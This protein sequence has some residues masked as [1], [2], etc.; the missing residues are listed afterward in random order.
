M[1]ALRNLKTAI[2]TR[3]VDPSLRPAN[4]AAAAGL[5][6]R[7]ANTLLASE[8]SSLERYIWTRRLERGRRLL[9]DCGQG[10]RSIADIAYAC[11]FSTPSHFTRRFKEAFGITPGEFRARRHPD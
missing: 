9:L 8:G 1:V 7:Y 3:V 6:V 5:S 10:H 2:E 11:G 4:A